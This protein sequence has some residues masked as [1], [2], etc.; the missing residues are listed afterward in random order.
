MGALEEMSTTYEPV[1]KTIEIHESLSL[2]DQERKL[3][4]KALNKHKDSLLKNG[5]NHEDELT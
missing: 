1:D 5:L 3:I 4:V 2:I